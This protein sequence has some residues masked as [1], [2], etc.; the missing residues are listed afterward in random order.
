MLTLSLFLTAFYGIQ[1]FGLTPKIY[2]NYKKSLVDTGRY[3]G[4]S[5]VYPTMLHL[6]S[7]I[8]TNME[9]MKM[10]NVSNSDFPDYCILK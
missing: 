4:M 5:V 1:A 3:M 10:Y 7:D 9:N 6:V 8:T 2:G